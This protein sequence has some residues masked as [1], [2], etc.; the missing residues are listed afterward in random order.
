MSESQVNPRDEGTSEEES[1]ETTDGDLEGRLPA[2]AVEALPEDLKGKLEAGESRLATEADV[3]VDPEDTY[4]VWEE[5]NL[6]GEEVVVG[7]ELRSITWQTKNQ[8]FKNNVE[9]RP[10]GRT[11]FELDVFQRDV[12][13]E[14]VVSHTIETDRSLRQILV[15]M[16]NNVGEKLEPHLPEPGAGEL[17]EAQEKN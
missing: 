3:L 15:G 16:D 8:I 12:A 1:A 10:S 13:E 14:V 17:E 6:Q 9:A 7:F 4:W 2:D 11:E 5:V